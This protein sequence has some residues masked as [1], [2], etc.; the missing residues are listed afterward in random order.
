MIFFIIVCPPLCRRYCPYGFVRVNGCP[1]CK[2][3]RFPQKIGQSCGAISG[4]CA[5][6]LFCRNGKCGKKI[7]VTQQTFTYSKYAIE[8]LE[9]VVEKL[10]KA[11][12]YDQKNQ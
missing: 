9:K 5:N 3:K 2:C 4:R 7:L 12:K 6:G 1:I 8:K 11:V 10:E